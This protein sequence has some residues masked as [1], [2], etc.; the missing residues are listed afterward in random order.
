NLQKLADQMPDRLESFS[1][2]SGLPLTFGNFVRFHDYDPE[3]LL[4]RKTWTQWKAGARV[5]ETPSDPDIDL[6]NQCLVSAAQ[7]SGP[8]EISRTR[9]VT[10]QLLAGDCKSAIAVAEEDN[11]SVMTHYRIWG[12]PGPKLG[13]ATIEEAYQR[14]TKNPSVLRDLDEVLAW[15]E[16]ESRLGALPLNL[17]FRCPLELHATYGGDEIKAALGEATF[18]SAWS[19]GVGV[20][21]FKAI[22]T[23]VALVTFQKTEKEFSPSTMYQDYPISRDLL[24][25]E[26]QASTSQTSDTGQNLIHHAERGYTM[27]FFVRSLK[28]VNYVTVP[29][30]FLG[31]ANLV[32]FESDRPIQM[33]W[34]LD[35]SMPVEIFEENRKGG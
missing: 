22:K 28:E 25:W 16:E 27:L 6:L 21:H 9:N 31:S 17:P 20:L 23:Y 7:T 32:S 8:R 12:K 35:H 10:R 30:T 33:V 29:F 34:R 24:H 3:A 14:A 1:T 18:Q 13:I 5:A 4:S 19:T 26:T 11:A 2:D 15:V